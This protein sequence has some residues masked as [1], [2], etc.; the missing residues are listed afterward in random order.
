MESET[1]AAAGAAASNSGTTTQEADAEQ[2]L[3]E[4]AAAKARAEEAHQ[5]LLYAMAEVDNVKK[6]SEKH[7]AERLASG[8]KMLLSKFLPVIDNLYRALAFEIASD[9]LRDGLQATL[10]GF[11]AALSSEQVRSVTVLGLPFDPRLAEAIGTR[12]TDDVPDNTVVDEVQRGYLLGED[13]LRPAQV[14]VSK[15]KTEAG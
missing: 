12:E 11:E 10:R 13:L 6:R 5:K 4:L 15:R 9:R 2:L 14:I 1:Q 8:R 3:G 7:V